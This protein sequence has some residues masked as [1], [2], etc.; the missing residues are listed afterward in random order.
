MIKSCEF[1]RFSLSYLF[2]YNHQ[3]SHLFSQ[4]ELVYLRSELSETK[5]KQLSAERDL[6]NVFLELHNKNLQLAAARGDS[7]PEHTAS[8]KEKLVGTHYPS[9]IGVSNTYYRCE[10][11]ASSLSSC[12]TTNS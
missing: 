6:E 11:R 9:L 2:L 10:S 4:A 7:S 5:A 12:A 1:G 8:I 3:T